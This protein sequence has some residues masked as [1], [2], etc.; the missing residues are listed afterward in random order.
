MKCAGQAGS[1][2]CTLLN[3]YAVREN[4]QLNSRKKAHNYFSFC[5]MESL[6]LPL[7]L[8]NIPG[9]SSNDNP[10]TSGPIPG[11]L[12]NAASKLFKPRKH[13]ILSKVP[14]FKKKRENDRNQY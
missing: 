4:M 13:C 6:I 11:Q 7:H 8:S 10:S 2:F 12:H 14:N 3:C 5:G 1:N 9:A